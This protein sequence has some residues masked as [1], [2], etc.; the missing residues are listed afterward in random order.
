MTADPMSA[1]YSIELT[2]KDHI[3]LEYCEGEEYAV[4]S[5]VVEIQNMK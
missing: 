5:E 2:D 1:I 3:I 4:V